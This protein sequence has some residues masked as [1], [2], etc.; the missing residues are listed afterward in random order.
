MSSPGGKEGEGGRE[1]GRGREIE[2][3]RGREGGRD[4]LYILQRITIWPMLFE[5]SVP[6][7]P[8][9]I[10]VDESPYS[11]RER[12]SPFLIGLPGVT[13][14]NETSQSDDWERGR[15]VRAGWT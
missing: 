1:R 2:R 11:A 5:A 6:G 10:A 3:E 8:T 12:K 9:D 13:R 7:S 14:G 4:S 15:G